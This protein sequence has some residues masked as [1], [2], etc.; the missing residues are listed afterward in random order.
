MIFSRHSG[1]QEDVGHRT[2]D[3]A[4]SDSVV[5]MICSGEV[6]ITLRPKYRYSS[7]PQPCMPTRL[8]LSLLS[9]TTL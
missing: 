1:D 3:Q 8:N 9:S 4:F 5:K 7:V 6:R 2:E